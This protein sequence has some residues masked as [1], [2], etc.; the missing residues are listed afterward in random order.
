MN[1]PSTETESETPAPEQPQQFKQTRWQRLPHA[2]EIMLLRHGATAPYTPGSEFPML[3][4]QGDPPLSDVGFQQAQLTAERLATEMID[5][6]YVTTLQRTHQT[7]AP[8]VSALGLEPMVEADLR[9]VELGEWDGGLIRMHAAQGHPL[10]ERVREEQRWDVIPGAES[11]DALTE[12]CINA[13]NAVA[14]RHVGQLVLCTVHGG[15]IAA[16]LAHITGSSPFAFGGSD[17]CAISQVV[18]TEGDWIMRRYNDS[19]H[20]WEWLH[21]GSDTPAQLLR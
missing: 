20:L 17:N 2:T 18:R 7:A 11:N 10:Y 14:D 12:R 13:L 8:L 21:H 3:D 6:I 15:V 16:L 4:G 1:Q 19:S 5:A 9:E